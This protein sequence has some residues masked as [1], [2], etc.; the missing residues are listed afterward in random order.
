MKFSFALLSIAAGA[1]LQLVGAGP[2][3]DVQDVVC[4]S[5]LSSQS[6]RVHY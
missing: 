4:A 1:A 6:Y 3:A 2:V 5:M